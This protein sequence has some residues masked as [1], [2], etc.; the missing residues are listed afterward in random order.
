[1]TEARLKRIVFRTS[2]ALD[3]TSRRELTAQIGHDPSA[4]PSVVIKELVDNAL[5]A[6]EE[7]ETAPE[8]AI[9]NQKMKKVT[10]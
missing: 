5:D 9:A 4:W 3:F 2:R 6:C 1:M 7:A 10:E 8:V